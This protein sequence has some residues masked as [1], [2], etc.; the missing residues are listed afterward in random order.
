[1]SP[2]KV[3]QIGSGTFFLK[4]DEVLNTFRN[5]PLADGT[6]ETVQTL[7]IIGK[8]NG[9][10]VLGIHSPFGSTRNFEAQESVRILRRSIL[11][12]DGTI[13]QPLSE[14]ELQNELRNLPSKER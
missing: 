14:E 7:T 8:E 6:P 9:F 1:M 4:K 10:R 5:K 13:V 11:L 2:A 12:P 3:F